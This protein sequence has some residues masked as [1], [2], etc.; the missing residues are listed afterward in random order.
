VRVIV[1]NEEIYPLDSNKP[2]LIRIKE[3]YPKIVV[4]DGFHFTE[5]IKLTYHEPSF[6]HFKVICAIDDIQLLG[7]SL[8]L[9]VFY[10]FGFF[11]GLFILKLISFLPIICFLALYYLNRRSFMKIVQDH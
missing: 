6:Y 10:L 8:F 11:S 2:V 5:P 9:I 4:T 1:N 7:G 3:N